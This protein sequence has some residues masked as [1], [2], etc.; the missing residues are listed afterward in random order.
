MTES[1]GEL[2]LEVTARSVGL[3][4]T[5]KE[6]G[7]R[8]E[9]LPEIKMKDDSCIFCKLA[10]GEI[11]T[12]K[13]YEDELFSVIMDSSPAS[14]GHSLILPKEHYADIYEITEDT[15]AKAMALAKRLAEKMTASLGC[16]GFNILQNNGE[17]AGQTVFHFHIHL[18]PRYKGKDNMILWSH[19][20]FGDEE[21][22]ALCAQLSDACR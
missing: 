18:I 12:R 10:N 14:R 16:D 22:D 4:Q 8:R 6:E 5:V 9:K 15:A 19:Q 20:E 7:G 13:I 21:M 11:P 1:D 2:I 17:T 3:S